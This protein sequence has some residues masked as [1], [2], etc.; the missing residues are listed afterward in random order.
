MNKPPK[1]KQKVP[2]KGPNS[3]DRGP[4]ISLYD[5][6]VIDDTVS[7]RRGNLG[8]ETINFSAVV[9]SFPDLVLDGKL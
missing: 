8:D 4:E 7:L 3:G 5:C 2:G 1:I 9:P 6:L